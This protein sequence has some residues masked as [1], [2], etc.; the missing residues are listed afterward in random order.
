MLLCTNPYAKLDF[1]LD[2]EVPSQIQIW[3]NQ[4]LTIQHKYF[5]KFV[6][7]KYII[8]WIQFD[9]IPDYQVKISGWHR[10]GSLYRLILTLPRASLYSFL[11]R[12][13]WSHCRIAESRKYFVTL[14]H[15]HEVVNNNYHLVFD[16]MN[17]WVFV[18]LYSMT[19]R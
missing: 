11:S 4:S 14:E 10:G 19:L 8:P 7:L 3:R 12:R 1:S 9:Q 15:S 16:S 17:L 13:V 5:W 2:F 6:K 18:H